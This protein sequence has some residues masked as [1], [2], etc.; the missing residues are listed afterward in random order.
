MEALVQDDEHSAQRE[1]NPPCTPLMSQIVSQGSVCS[2]FSGL[3]LMLRLQVTMTTISRGRSTLW[4]AW[5]RFLT[6]TRWLVQMLESLS[7]RTSVAGKSAASG[8]DN[9]LS[10]FE[11]PQRLLN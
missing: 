2:A 1:M 8:S 4:F 10:Q 6:L 9:P 3:W 5:Q 11:N 7:T